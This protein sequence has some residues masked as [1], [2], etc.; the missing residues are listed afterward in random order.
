MN[1]GHYLITKIKE[2]GADH[3]FGI[4]GDYTLNFIN[5]VVKDPLIEY[6]GMSREDCAGYAADAYARLKGIGVVSV[7]YGVGAMNVMNA[8][9]GAFAERSPL[10]IISGIPGESEL[11]DS[12]NKH[13]TINEIDTQRVIFKNMTVYTV[14]IDEETDIETALYKIQ[15]ALCL[16]KYHSRPVYIEIAN[17]M[18]LKEIPREIKKS[19]STNVFL[20][21]VTTL[22]NIN[23][24]KNIISLMEK[25]FERCKKPFMLIGHEVFRMCLETEILEFI[26]H[27]NIPF[28]TSL[29]GKG[30]IPSTHSL[31]SGVYSGMMGDP[32][33]IEMGEASDCFMVI[34][35]NTTDFD[36]IVGTPTLIANMDSTQ[37]MG[38][39]YK[40]TDFFNVISN[41]LS[42]NIETTLGNDWLR[43]FPKTPLTIESVRSRNVRTDEL[44]N[45]IGK[46]LHPCHTLIADIG[47]SLFGAIDLPIPSS[48]GFLCMPYYASMSYSM[49]GA[50]GARLAKPEK[51]P[52]VIIGDGAFQMTGS[53]F[54]DMIRYNTNAIIIV[55]NNKGYA[56]ERAIMDGT[57]NDIHDWNYSKMPHVMNG[58]VGYKIETISEFKQFFI[59]AINTPKETFIFDVIIEPGD[60][61]TAMKRTGENLSRNLK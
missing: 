42:L 56:T 50:I 19:F 55:L 30:S 48:G 15:K 21:S 11:T 46:S 43:D 14:S 35:C 39:S 61:T 3:L 12:S 53:A 34:G 28:C 2:A 31:N 22:K 5:E 24:T 52:I 37:Y 8:V 51:R 38:R 45:F 16:M 27:N 29:L 47:E 7:T 4:P 17:K 58:G 26:E 1:L 49:P 36:S 32:R 9:G 60:S 44:F 13:H 57:F 20:N 59:S 6:V 41:L 10:C 25:Q 18:V 23:D 33:L 54:G 40:T